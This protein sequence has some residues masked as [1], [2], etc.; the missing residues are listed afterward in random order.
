MPTQRPDPS[1]RA[2]ARRY[3]TLLGCNLTCVLALMAALH[4]PAA[5]AS[6]TQ[7]AIIEDD[8]AL[9]AN[10][11]ATLAQMR[12][13]GATTV[14]IFVT[15][16][17][18]AP[19]PNW[20]H[21]PRF[22]AA[23]PAAYPRAAWYLLD[24]EIRQAAA[25][26][27]GVYLVV[28]G[29]VPRWAQGPGAPASGPLGRLVWEPNAADF[30]AFV[31]ALGIRYDGRY[32]VDGSPLPRV[33][34][35][36]IWNEP[37]YGY[38]LGPQSSGTAIQH[39]AALYR[40]L[41][42]RGYAALRASGH[43]HDT[44][45]FGEIAPHGQANGGDFAGVAPLVF[46]RALYCVNASYHQLRG[47]LA[48]ANGCPATGAAS[49]RF[50]AN[51]PALFDAS[52]LAAHLYAQDTPP[53]RSLDDRCVRGQDRAAYADL[54]DVGRLESTLDRL[55]RAYGSRRRMPIYNTEYGYQTHPP[56][57][58]S[59]A[60]NS[61]PVSIPTAAYYI[62]WAEYISYEDPQIKSYAQYLLTDPPTGNFDS[63]LQF[64]DGRPKQPLFGA[65]ML[66]LYMPTTNVR[67]PSRLQVWGAVRPWE[68]A[69]LLGSRPPAALLEL[70][71]GRRGPWRTIARI[72]HVNQ[73]GYFD[74]RI[75][76]AHG[77]SLRLLWDNPLAGRTY[78]SRTIVVKV[79]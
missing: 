24:A 62:N 38:N 3:L 67:R 74:L 75:R 26:H 72:T 5:A 61:L 18:F 36:S 39:S 68:N 21:R 73:S 13:L 31:K 70:H 41:L 53:D 78:V 66:P 15:W 56:Q 57:P 7:L 64:A 63:G 43:G 20:R 32:R 51:N 44:I 27:I 77:G 17:S 6:A 29:P 35:W 55:Q 4:V 52:G 59:C 1:W 23:D 50:R 65:Y 48:R 19:H 10:P 16:S 30:G 34:F 76:F 22:N 14:R 60:K 8:A 11:A 40:A 9:A 47:A 45:L 54:G 2:P 25:D 49:R 12:A 46:L 58:F 71:Y 37:N 79:R 28:T 69:K 42:D 33:N